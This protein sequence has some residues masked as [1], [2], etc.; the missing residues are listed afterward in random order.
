MTLSKVTIVICHYAVSIALILLCAQSAYSKDL[1]IEHQKLMLNASFTH[2]VS[3]IEDGRIFLIL[4][5]TLAHG[6]MEIVN[7][8]QEILKEED[9]KVL[10]ITLSLGINNRKGMYNCELPHNH[11]HKDAQEEL[12]K[13]IEWLIEHGAQEIILVGHSRG[14]MQVAEYLASNNK[15]QIQGA[16]LLAPPATSKSPLGSE[17][18][19][20]PV[21]L[22]NTVSSQA[23]F[24]VDRFLHCQ[25]SVVSSTSLDSYYGDPSSG[26]DI[27]ETIDQISTPTI[28]FLGSN[29][30]IV[31]LNM[32]SKQSNFNE[33]IKVITV[34]GAGHF[35]RDLYLYDIVDS[36]LIWSQ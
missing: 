8:L 33:N 36:V 16:V 4:H 29:D 15:K 1:Q 24:K 27:F 30:P 34:D 32:W 11:Q 35:F 13:W 26:I 7:S 19:P 23:Y 2:N 9:E 22:E 28:I 3:D 21:K 20:M 5:G 10:A 25:E 18:T 17:L 12:A 6:N 14:A 31:D